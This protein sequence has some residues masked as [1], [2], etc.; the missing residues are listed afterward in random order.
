MS[1]ETFEKLLKGNTPETVI[2]VEAFNSAQE[3][4]TREA[5]E[6]QAKATKSLMEGFLSPYQGVKQELAEAIRVM[7]KAKAAQE[8]A[9]R[10]LTY[11]YQTRNPLPLFATL[12]MKQQGVEWCVLNNV[13]VPDNNSPLWKVPENWTPVTVG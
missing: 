2:P 13:P 10:A 5:A 1:Q 11:F 6:K 7:E 4:F 8:A 12:F 9:D 3:I